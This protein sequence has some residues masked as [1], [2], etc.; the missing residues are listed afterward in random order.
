MPSTK[1]KGNTHDRFDNG[2]ISVFACKFQ[3]NARKLI[4]RIF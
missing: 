4:K 2:G 1:E 3:L